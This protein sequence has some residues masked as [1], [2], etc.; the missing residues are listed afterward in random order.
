MTA[1]IQHDPSAFRKMAL[2]PGG[3]P[4][5][6]ALRDANEAVESVSGKGRNLIR[7]NIEHLDMLVGDVAEQKTL[8]L[9]YRKSVEIAEVAG[10]LKMQQ[11]ARVATS[12]NEL[13]YRMMAGEST[14]EE[15]F[16]VHVQALKLAHTAGKAGLTDQTAELLIARLGKVV[17]QIPDPDAALKSEAHS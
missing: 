11:V 9:T 3:K 4:R 17:D 15:S 6:L 7:M 10:F 1:E 14:C 16:A 5:E 8:E 13:V 12:L 2:R